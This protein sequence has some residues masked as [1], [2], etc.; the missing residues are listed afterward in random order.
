MRRSGAPQGEGL[1]ER[2]LNE[3]FDSI[4]PLTV[5]D[6]G[7]GFNGRPDYDRLL[8]G[9]DV[10]LLAFEP[11]TA[12]REALVAHY[13]ESVDHRFHPDIL[14]GGG[15]RTFHQTEFP[16][17]ASLYRPDEARRAP[18]G[19]V[20]EAGRLQAEY[21][22]ET[23]RLDDVPEA[24]AAD[25]LTMD[26]QGAELDVL[27]G[28]LGVLE[29]RPVIQA[30]AFFV[31]LYENMPLFADLDAFLR[32]RGY[33]FHFLDKISTRAFK[34]AW[35]PDDPGAGFR[36]MIHCDA[37]YVPD[38]L[39]LDAMPPDRLLKTARILHDLYRSI[40]FVR[41]VLATHD[42]LTGSA[43]ADPSM[44]AVCEGRV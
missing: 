13:G 36:Q 2:A 25:L 16:F 6:V 8:E 19:T 26:I 35:R 4:P 43:L 11:Q 10:T 7:A 40:D 9:G 17:T 12:L 42:R 32:G 18:L 39:T 3:L 5:V 28:A 23:R 29:A 30:E 22:V 1:A 34:P 14:G 33:Q 38:Y 21:R 41:Y 15:P 20:A 24:A 44:A 31:P 37:I 27:R